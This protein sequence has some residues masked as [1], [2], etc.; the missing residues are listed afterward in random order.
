MQ[1][2]VIDAEVI[3][4]VIADFDLKGMTSEFYAAGYDASAA[5]QGITEY[6]AEA[7][8]LRSPG[9]SGPDERGIHAQER[10]M[11]KRASL[12][13]AANGNNGNLTASDALAYLQEVIEGMKS[14]SATAGPHR[15]ETGM[16]IRISTGRPGHFS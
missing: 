6:E 16:K 7:G 3:A 9:E 14:R 5:Y 4:E 1:R 15:S 2:A 8:I 13:P 12:A 11:P 10:M